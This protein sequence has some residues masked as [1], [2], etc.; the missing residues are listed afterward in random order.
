[1]LKGKRERKKTTTTSVSNE[2]E[3]GNRTEEWPITEFLHPHLQQ[4]QEQDIMIIN[5]QVHQQTLET[6]T[7]MY[8]QATNQHPVITHMY[9]HLLIL[10]Q[11]WFQTS[12]HQLDILHQAIT[13]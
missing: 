8:L 1:M 9:E 2:R 12:I 4:E 3:R 6:T 7:I 5:L 11:E 10:H 13:M